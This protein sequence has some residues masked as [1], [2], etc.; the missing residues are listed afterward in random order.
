MEEA[1]GLDAEVSKGLGDED[2]DASGGSA[3]PAGLRSC[4]CEEVL[5]TELMLSREASAC[6]YTS[7]LSLAYAEMT[8]YGSRE[9][10]WP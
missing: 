4:A 10:M 1:A 6:G 8:V 3:S 2:E 5:A 9:M 7:V